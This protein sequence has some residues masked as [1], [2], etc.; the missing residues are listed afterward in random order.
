MRHARMPSMEC[1]N[2]RMGELNQIIIDLRG[3]KVIEGSDWE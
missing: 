1:N 3:S 2:I